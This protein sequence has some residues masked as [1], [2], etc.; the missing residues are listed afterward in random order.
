M[1]R[2]GRF[3]IIALLMLSFGCS[4]LRRVPEGESFLRKNNIRLTEKPVD[5][6]IPDEELTSLIRQKPNRKILWFRFNHS[7][8][9]MVNKD[10][11]EED[12]NKSNIKCE[13]KNQKRALKKKPARECKTWRM[14]WAYTVGEPTV[15]LD[16][17]KMIKSAEQ[18]EIFLNKKGYFD[19]SVEPEV[20]YN[21]KQNKCRVEYIIKPGESYKIRNITYNFVDT[22]MA[23]SLGYIKETSTLDSTMRFDIEA[24]DAERARIA[25][26]YNN[27]GYF[28]F[29]KDYIV[30]D[31]DS[32]IPNRQV[33][34]VMKLE[35][36]KTSSVQFP[37]S[38][39]NVPHKKY[40][41]GDIYIH[42]DFDPARLEDLKNDTINF[43]GLKILYS[44]KL[45]FS[46]TLISCTQAFQSGELYQ[47]SRIDNTYKRYS[48]LG[49]MRATTIQL[50]PRA[51][52][53][54]NKFY[55]LDS[56][57]LL[58]PAKKQ[59]LSFDPRVTHRDGNMGIYANFM[60]RHKNLF[61]GAESLDIRI[62]AGLEAS[63]SLVNGYAGTGVTTENITRSFRLNTFEI[64]PEITYRVPRLWPLSCDRIKK[65]SEPSASIGG[66]LNYQT[67]PDYQRTLS[68]LKFSWGW[69]ENPDKGRRINLDWVEF[70]V[71][72]IQNSQAFQDFIKLQNNEY[73]ANSYRDHL[74]FAS[75]VSLTTNTQ[76]TK[77][78]R[79]YF[80]WKIG[81]SAAGNSL[82]L[83]LQNSKA[84]P[85]SLGSYEIA[86]IRF[87]QYVRAENDLR[88]YFNANEKNAFVLRSYTGVGK[89]GV[90]LAALPFEKSFFSGG[91]NGI[92]A[93][94]ARTL[95]PGSSRDSLFV[96]TF[97]NIGEFKI[98]GN[99]EYR[100]KMTQMLN[101]ALFL[102]VGNIWLLKKDANKPG[103]D[104]QADRWLG[105][106]AIGAGIGLRLDF[107]F[108][109]VRT[110][111]GLQLKDPA[112]IP[113]E[114]WLWQPKDEYLDFIQRVQPGT[115]S[116]PLRSSLVFN[117]GI[118]FP[119]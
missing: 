79:T 31:A 90:N 86:G 8:Y 95:G 111:L 24:L 116:V 78:Q 74:I 13:R 2:T 20:L 96:R 89:S 114:R 22:E 91:A 51:A 106:L 85:D 50:T 70:S 1:H 3:F 5:Y 19:A 110:D 71:I 92:R 49:I 27:K 118:G 9:L 47:R 10:K 38:L 16:S 100:F 28:D 83:L 63:Q 80:Y 30:Y 98:E 26:Y 57:I 103:A 107:D 44:G 87:A 46:P 117:L 32:T 62:I 88:F 55:I 40:F 113:G 81:V 39:I 101:W 34:I 29:T 97:N 43:D 77:F 76:K 105:E 25:N 102:D 73:L 84:Q 69:I 12:L 17:A 109:L 82:R 48:Q 72:K 14:F 66:A 33:D 94:Q 53:D 35:Q 11:L 58:T 56:H 61:R 4:K 99:F 60:Y 21:K 64:G 108:F 119:F 65:S 23:K 52:A 15:I 68:Q 18:M 104:F 75:G 41:I 67:R 54:S 59:A 112:K 37:D 36:Q 42:T 6:D 93:W 45:D 115:A 7:I